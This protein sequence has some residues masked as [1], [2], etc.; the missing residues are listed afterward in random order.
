MGSVNDRSDELSVSYQKQNLEFQKRQ[1][2]LNEVREQKD[3][4]DSGGGYN[5]NNTM[6]DASSV[7]NFIKSEFN[8]SQY[9]SRNTNQNRAS[10]LSQKLSLLID[11]SK[12][13]QI[14]NSQNDKPI[15]KLKIVRKKQLGSGAQG[16]VYLVTIEGMEGY[17]VEKTCPQIINNQQLADEF[18]K[19]MFNEFYIAKDLSHPNINNYRYFKKNHD[20]QTKICEINIL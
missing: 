1:A 3:T 10:N 4:S 5:W 8:D 2:K 7:R 17:Y 6:S 13:I 14:F 11:H 18:I 20:P 12:P 9:N 19:S 15:N 16:K